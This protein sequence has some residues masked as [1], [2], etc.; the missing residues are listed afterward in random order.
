VLSVRIQWIADGVRETMADIQDA[1][2]ERYDDRAALAVMSVSF[3]TIPPTGW[4]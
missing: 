4:W 3:F 1:V 2:Y